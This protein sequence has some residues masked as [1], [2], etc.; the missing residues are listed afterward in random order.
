M[1]SATLTATATATAAVGNVVTDNNKDNDRDNDDV[2]VLDKE[3]DDVIVLE[4]EEEEKNKVIVLDEDEERKEDVIL[5]E[6]EK[7][8]NEHDGK[9][10]NDEE[11]KEKEKEKEEE[12]E[13]ENVIAIPDDPEDPIERL[14]NEMIRSSTVSWKSFVDE[15]KRSSVSPDDNKD[16]PSKPR[17]AP[18][19]KKI[20]PIEVIDIDEYEEDAKQDKSVFFEDKKP[21]SA[22]RVY[23]FN[24]GRPGHTGPECKFPLF[25]EICTVIPRPVMCRKSDW[26][27]KYAMDTVLYGPRI[28]LTSARGIGNFSLLPYN[29]SPSPSLRRGTSPN[30][31]GS[32]GRLVQFCA[33]SDVSDDS[34]SDYERSR[35]RSGKRKGGS[36]IKEDEDIDDEGMVVD[37]IPVKRFK[38]GESD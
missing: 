4:E 28:P 7:K 14:T 18:N 38:K 16:R 35:K 22:K 30:L 25:E 26:W 17:N 11:E 20:I 29:L 24:C 9:E 12:K 2:I 37:F 33:S 32:G 36:A 31:G 19:K 1:E 6:E 10:K 21:G 8:E 27:R 23:C 13:E 34:D 3:E 15:M 5:L